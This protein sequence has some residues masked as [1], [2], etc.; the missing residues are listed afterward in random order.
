VVLAGECP[1]QQRA[2]GKL[3]CQSEVLPNV[4]GVCMGCCLSHKEIL[5][6]MPLATW[7]IW[8]LREGL[9][10]L[11]IWGG[12][13][14]CIRRRGPL[15]SQHRVNACCSEAVAL[16]QSR[17]LKKYLGE[18]CCVLEWE[19]GRGDGTRSNIRA[20]RMEVNCLGEC[21]IG[22]GGG[23]G[24]LL[25]RNCRALGR[26]WRHGG[27]DGG[28]R[29]VC[30]I[31]LVRIWGITGVEYQQLLHSFTRPL[32]ALSLYLLVSLFFS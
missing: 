15:Y 20:G 27:W 13:L 28:R 26:A 17:Q 1:R 24:V 14:P 9:G 4:H 12:R 19:R 21:R 8:P 22:M 11:M 16:V 32:P 3:L 30:G 29:V 6:R 25:S 31:S 5:E 2:S 10:A 23:G 18:M 7:R